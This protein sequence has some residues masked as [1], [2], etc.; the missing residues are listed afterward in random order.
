MVGPLV[1][2]MEWGTAQTAGLLVSLTAATLAIGC[3]AITS[4]TQLLALNS[5]I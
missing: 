5:R 4:W 1:Q 2:P 3:S